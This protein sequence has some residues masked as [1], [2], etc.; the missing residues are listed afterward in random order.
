VVK[1]ERRFAIRCMKK[2][3]RRSKKYH[4]HDEQNGQGRRDR[5]HRGVRAAVQAEA[6]GSSK[7][8]A[9]G[10]REEAMP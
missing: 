3:M 7:N 10:K 1:V 6:L 9:S 8:L 2:T 4:A 5:P